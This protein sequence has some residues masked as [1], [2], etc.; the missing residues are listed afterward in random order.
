[1]KKHSKKG[2]DESPGLF[3]CLAAPVQRCK[4]ARH[5]AAPRLQRPRP[6]EVGI[7]DG[8][9]LARATIPAMSRIKAFG[10]LVAL[11]V[12][13]L[14]PL[15][16]WLGRYSG[17]PDVFAWTPLFALFV[18]LP[19][20]DYAIGHDRSNPDPA[21]AAE[22]E[23]QP[24]FKLLT[25][26]CLPLQVA[27]LGWSITHLGSAGYGALGV[28]GWLLSQGVV[29][30][31]IAINVA[32]E[33]IHKDTALE[34][35]CGGLLL[36]TVGYHGFKIE[37]IRGHH[38]HVSTPLDSSSAR[39][40]QSVW[41]FLPAALLQNSSNAWR[42]EAARLARKGLPWWHW[43]NEM[44]GWTLVWL[45]MAAVAGA[46]FGVAGLAFFLAQGL[47]AAITLEIINYIEHYGLERARLAD[48]RFERTTH[49]HSWNSDYL[50]SNLLLFQLQRH[51][52]HHE[53]PRRRYQALLHHD[54]SPQLP[55][56]YAAMFLLALVPPLWRRVIDPRVKAF[57]QARSRVD[58]SPG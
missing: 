7:E 34:R 18:L 28:A 8:G 16:A 48:G 15:A 27:L 4:P 12:P 52:D 57:R 47:V 31:I 49:L 13:A 58:T 46:V 26:L 32:H 11:L 41:A 53:T 23:Q 45:A 42:L 20:L 55:G 33:L 22:L 25:L 39:S 5:A 37:H 43:R 19:L 6:G 35:A 24:G 21:T 2:Q 17:A 10:F 56:G 51:S 3:C 54:D 30:G 38:V 50:V 40:G 44:L 1:M 36:C 9:E 14:L 29:S